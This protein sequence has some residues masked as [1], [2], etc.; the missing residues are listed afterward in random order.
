MSE[1]KKQIKQYKII[2]K[3]H[4]EVLEK[5]KIRMKTFIEILS[6]DKTQVT[7]ESLEYLTMNVTLLTYMNKINN[8]L[9][10]VLE[11]MKTLN[12]IEED[13]KKE[14]IE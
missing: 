13:L 4:D 5:L 6:N 1:I 10:E 8:D 12:N 3:K 9:T 2:V 11:A 14:G 7:K